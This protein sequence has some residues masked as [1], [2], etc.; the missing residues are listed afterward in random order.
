MGTVRVRSVVSRA[1]DRLCLLF[2]LQAIEQRQPE[3]QS[4]IEGVYETTQQLLRLLKVPEREP[5]EY[6]RG[7]RQLCVD[8]WSAVKAKLGQ[9]GARLSALSLSIALMG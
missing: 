5:N 6:E 7:A 4:S 3:A 8:K 2:T 9:V 1:P